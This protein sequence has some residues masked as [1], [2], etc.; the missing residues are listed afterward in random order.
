MNGRR[1]VVEP[2]SLDYPEPSAMV[3]EALS[4]RGPLAELGAGERFLLTAIVTDPPDTG[5]AFVRRYFDA[6]S[7]LK[8]YEGVRY[9]FQASE[10]AEFADVVEADLASHGS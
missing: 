7:V 3:D 4:W 9:V 5:D 10:I 6:V 1:Q 8:E 2:I